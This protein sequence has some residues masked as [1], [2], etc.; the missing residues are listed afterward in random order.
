MA[1]AGCWIRAAAWR[2]SRLTG[3]AMETW[4]KSNDG[5]AD[6]I[7]VPPRFSNRRSGSRKSSNHGK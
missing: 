5:Y 1:C 4:V 7:G 6:R 3:G 2:R